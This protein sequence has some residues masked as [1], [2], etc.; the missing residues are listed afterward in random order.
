MSV[1]QNRMRFIYIFCISIFSNFFISAQSGKNDET[2]N[3]EDISIRFSGEINT[4]VQQPDGKIIVGGSFGTY[5]GISWGIARL[6]TDG[7]L[8]TTFYVGEGAAGAVN[9]IALQN[10]GKILVA[11]AFMFFDGSSV[12]RIARL[13]TNGTVDSSFVSGAGANNPINKIILQSDGKIL[14]GGEFSRYQNI[15]TSRIARLNTDGSLDTTFNIGTGVA[16][17]VHDIVVQPNGKLIIGGSFTSYNSISKNRIVRLEP[18]GS[19]DTTFNIGIGANNTIYTIGISNIGKIIIGGDFTS[20]NGSTKNRIAMLNSDGTA[21]IYFN[22]YSGPNS[23]IR[24]VAIQS[25]GKIL[26]AG[27]FGS[28]NGN[29]SGGVARIETDGSFDNSFNVGTGTNNSITTICLQSDNSLILGGNFYL[30]NSIPVHRIV[31]LNQNGERDNT[32]ITGTGLSLHGVIRNTI[33]QPDKKIIIGGSFSEFN[34]K[35]YYSIARLNPD[36]SLDTTFQSVENNSGII[37]DFIQQSDGKIIIGGN[38]TQYQGVESNY[39]ARLNSNGS[40]DN[41]FL[42][43]QYTHGYPG[44][45]AVQSD[46]K[47]IASTGYGNHTNNLMRL[48]PD[49]SLDSTFSA[50]T[51]VTGS[52][53]DVEVYPDGKILIAGKFY[54][55]NGVSCRDIA[56]LHP[57]GTLDL[58]FS[59]NQGINNSGMIKKIVVLSDGKILAGGDFYTMNGQN[60]Q[61]KIVRLNTN[62]TIDNTFLTSTASSLFQISSIYDLVIQPDDKILV[63]GLF[64]KYWGKSINNILRLNS[65]GSIDTTFNVGLGAT[66]YG[67]LSINP[68]SDSTLIIA[69]NFTNYDGIPRN[70]IARIKNCVNTFR[71]TIVSACYSFEWYG[72]TYTESGVYIHT[73][74]NSRGCD[75]IIRLHLNVYVSGS[76]DS[77]VVACGSFNLYGIEYPETGIYTHVQPLSEGCDSVITLYLTILQPTIGDTSSMV[78]DSFEWYGITYNESGQYTHTFI[79]SVGCDSTVTLHLTVNSSSATDTTVQAINNFEWYG[80]TYNESGEYIHTLLNKW[81]CDSTVTLHL[82]IINTVGTLANSVDNIQIFPNPTHHHITISGIMTGTNVKL[83]D[84]VGNIIYENIANYSEI[85]VDFS[86]YSSGVYLLELHYIDFYNIYEIIKP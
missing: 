80:I 62:G 38:F 22:P 36:G 48:N 70:G 64:A 41:T 55:Y 45:L 24:D 37:S 50:G 18:D 54:S 66:H 5:N 11:G 81:G 85:I 8:D 7:T 60:V 44:A 21:T 39:I 42:L 28:F 35:K 9:S 26:I 14:I 58:S 15:L 20:Y 71:D 27:N 4:L 77:T 10:D 43:G 83:L 49:G 52:I 6:N 65:D 67:V 86:T 63:G 33:I 19:I 12:G 74:V 84:I 32:F 40:I 75:S 68:Q 23:T 78:C 25:N 34:R 2:F 13:N 56:R 53:S 46:G 72:N 82:T 3:V 51:G 17:I 61:N 73:L 59:I 31:R 47:I 57:D 79:N 1:K 76:K 16:G 69:G 29:I 30:Y